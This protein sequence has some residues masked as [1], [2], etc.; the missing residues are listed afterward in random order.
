MSAKP[1]RDPVATRA[2]LMEAAE[3]VFL[4][5]GYGNTSL[6]EIARR[7]GMTKSLIHHYFGSKDGLW[8][9]VKYERF[10]QYA[11]RQIEML[12]DAKPTAEL[13]RASLAFYFDFL[14]RNPQIVRILA[15]MF[16]EQDQDDCLAIDRELVAKGV[17]KIRQSQAE[18]QLRADIDPR[19]I[20]FVFI[21]LCQHWFQD[22]GHFI[23]DFG[24]EGLPADLDEAYLA[25]IIKIFFEGLLPR[26]TTPPSQ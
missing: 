5:K 3:T 24:T 16:L 25:S 22:K 26:E 23:N 14:R 8:R 19:F 10:T 9:E 13:L 1:Q 21:G 15:W 4:E 17:E 12:R 20:L 11:Q 18:G 7:A 6:S 2:A